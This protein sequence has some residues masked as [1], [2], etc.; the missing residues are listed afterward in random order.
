MLIWMCGHT[1]NYEIK[2]K[3]IQDKIG[4]ALAEMVRTC[5]QE[6][7]CTNEQVREVDILG[8]KS[9]MRQAKTTLRGNQTVHKTSSAIK[10]MILDSMIWRLDHKDKRQYRQPNIVV[11]VRIYVVFYCPNFHYYLLPCYLTV[12]FCYISNNLFYPTKVG[13]Q[14]RTRVILSPESGIILYILLFA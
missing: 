13:N 3:V 14:I 4:A 10:D 5:E 11:L 9:S 8:F 7:R 12:I 1:R 2:N 6:C